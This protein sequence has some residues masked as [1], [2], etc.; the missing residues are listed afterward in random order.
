MKDYFKREKLDY[1]DLKWWNACEPIW[2]TS[3]RNELKTAAYF[4]PGSDTLFTNSSL[5]KKVP[6]NKYLTFENKTDQVI[7]WFLNENYMF[8]LMYHYQPD[9]IRW[10]LSL[11]LKNLFFYSSFFIN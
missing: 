3:A 1:S 10:A 8:V 5:Y 9:Q 11:V 7:D 4:W 2:F 6:Y